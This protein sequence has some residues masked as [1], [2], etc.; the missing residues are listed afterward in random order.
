MVTVNGDI[1]ATATEN[2]ATAKI[3]TLNVPLSVI[4]IWIKTLSS[5]TTYTDVYGYNLELPGQLGQPQR[6]WQLVYTNIPPG[7]RVKDA[8]ED[9]RFQLLTTLIERTSPVTA[10]ATAA[11]TLD[12]DI[13]GRYYNYRSVREM[14]DEDLDDLFNE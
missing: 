1:V 2:T 10:A 9:L 11:N 12:G 8:S 13:S 4:E 14:T 3:T 5:S 6:L 7:F